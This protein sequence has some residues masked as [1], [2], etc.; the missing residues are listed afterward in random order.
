MDTQKPSIG[1]IALAG[2][3][4]IFLGMV[5]YFLVMKF[6]GFAHIP[7][8]RF[9]NVLIAAAGGIGA[10]KYYNSHADKH[11]K[12]LNGF[13]LSF[14]TIM[15]GSMLFSF[16]IFCYFTFIDPQLLTVISIDAPM[17]G[18]HISPFTTLISVVSEGAVSGLVISFILM[19]YFKDDNL[20]APYK[21]A[22][23]GLRTEEE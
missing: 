17:T 23:G 19:Q 6:A 18:I 2:G 3:L 21:P 22:S 5:L 10:I 14:T 16:F 7:E 1:N 4:F 11:I 13:M 8:L 20:H 9:L 15:I 12:Y